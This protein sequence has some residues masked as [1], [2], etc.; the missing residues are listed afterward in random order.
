[1]VYWDTTG[2]LT[3]IDLPHLASEFAEF[4]STGRS[5]E[6]RTRTALLALLDMREQPQNLANRRE[7]R[8]RKLPHFPHIDE[9]RTSLTAYDRG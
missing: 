3:M 8:S 2:R 7:E 5:S 1:M 4:F 6:R 9:V